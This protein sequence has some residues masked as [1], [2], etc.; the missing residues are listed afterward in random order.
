MF[1]SSEGITESI[2]AYKIEHKRHWNPY[3]LIILDTAG[4]EAFESRRVRGTQ[5]TDIDVLVAAVVRWFK[6]SDNKKHWM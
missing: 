3:K 2:S 6:A 1:I 4:H 5:I